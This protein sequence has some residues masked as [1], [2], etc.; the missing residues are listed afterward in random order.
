[1][2]MNK[3]ELVDSIA[4]KA[5]ISKAKAQ[6][7]LNSFIEET[8]SALKKGD[9]VALIGFGTFSVGERSARKGRNPQTGKEIDI[10][11][12]RTIKFKAGKELQEKM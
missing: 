7:A 5:D 12:K 11:A 1:M 6:A 3:G 8:G 2:L 10:P 9:K 4:E